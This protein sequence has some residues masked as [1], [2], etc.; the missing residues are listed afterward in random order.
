MHLTDLQIRELKLKA[1]KS[2]MLNEGAEVLIRPD[3]L[4]LMITQ[5]EDCDLV[6]ARNEELERLLSDM[7]V[8]RDELKQ[9]VAQLELELLDLT[10]DEAA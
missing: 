3:D 5:L 4:L 10:D 9:D 2:L 1:E 7:E 6:E 8:Q